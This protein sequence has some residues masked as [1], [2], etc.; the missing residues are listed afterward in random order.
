[1]ISSSFSFFLSSQRCSKFSFVFLMF[2]N[3]GQGGGAGCGGGGCM[4]GGLPHPHLA[5]SS[6][7]EAPRQDAEAAV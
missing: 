4:C 7:R 2:S 1:M 6:W 5:G 3:C